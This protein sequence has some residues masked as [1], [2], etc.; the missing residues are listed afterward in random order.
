MATTLTQLIDSFAGLEVLVIGDVMLDSYLKG[1]ADRLCREAPVP[2]VTLTSRHDAPG[3]AANTAANLRS[4]GANVTLLAAVGDDAEAHSLRRA[5][6]DYDVTT[7]YLIEQPGRQTLAKHRVMAESHTLV[8]FDQGTTDAVDSATEKALVDQLMRLFSRCHAVLISDYNYGIITPRIISTLATLQARTPR[9]LVVDSKRLRAYRKLQVTAIKPNY[10]EALQLLGTHEDS[11]L[12]SRTQFIAGYGERILELTGAHIAA[13][14]MDSEGAWLFEHGNPAYRTYAQPARASGVA[15]AGD[16]YVSA[17]TLAL[18]AGGES[19]AAAELAAAAAEIVVARDGTAVCAADEL[20]AA[21]AAD[22]KYSDLA[23]LV[24]IVDHYRQ[25]GRR[26][27]FTNGCFDILHRGHVTYLSRAK[28]LGDVLI[29]GVNTDASIHRLK[30][31]ERPI[32]ALEDRVHVLAALSCVDHLVAFD[33][34]TPAKLIEAIRPDIFVKGGDYTRERLPEAGLV[35]QLGGTV[36]ILP[37]LPNRS[38]TLMIERIRSASAGTIAVS[39]WQ[40]AAAG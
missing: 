14:T 22:T 35:E 3:G 20:R 19:H 8:R 2:I 39:N 28:A 29:L 16:T 33:E 1:T 17:L 40:E 4:L 12:G 37:F 24:A 23:R 5:L 15:G 13:V 21:V 26:I 36:E 31:P 18:A 38:T 7:D 9:T 27:V 30:G 32:N 11:K 6:A 25:Q 34:D 10:Q